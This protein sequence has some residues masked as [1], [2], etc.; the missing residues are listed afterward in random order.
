[1]RRVYFGD[2]GLDETRL[3]DDKMGLRKTPHTPPPDP[4]PRTDA[5]PKREGK[6]DRRG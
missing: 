3:D 2:I 6:V 1:M 4:T 5:A